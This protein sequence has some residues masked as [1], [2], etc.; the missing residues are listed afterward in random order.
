M[1]PVPTAP[2]PVVVIPP[3]VV[4]PTR[5]EGPPP[6]VPVANDAPGTAAP[7]ADGLRVTF[8]PD[9]AN[10]NPGT[11][12]AL[13]TLAEKARSNDTPISVLAYAPGNADDPSAPRRLSLARGLAARAVLL[14]SGIAS[15]RIYVRALGANMQGGPANRVDVTLAAPGPAQ[16][17]EKVATP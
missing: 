10:L 9:N 15:T 6:P 12:A 4:V 5:P 11:A 1:P 17:P 3:P 2:P 7:I 13:K 14:N 16:S 8:G